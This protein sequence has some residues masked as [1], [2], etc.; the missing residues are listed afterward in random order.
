M[1]V[2]EDTLYIEWLE[3][4]EAGVPLG[5]LKSARNLN[6]KSWFF[7]N[8]PDDKRRVLCSY[9]HLKER[10]QTMICNKFGNPYDYVAKQPIRD[11]VQWDSTAEEYFLNYRYDGDKVLSRSHVDKYTAAAN[12]LNM[13]NKAC[14]D[15]KQ[16]KKLLG[17]TIDQFY[18]HVT[19]LIKIEKVSLPASY[20]NLKIKQKDYAENGYEVLVSPHFG[21]KRSAKVG[22]NKSENVLLKLLSHP[23]QYDDVFI[24]NQ[25]NEWAKSEGY[26]PITSAAVR[27][28]RVKNEELLTFEREG[29]SAFK[30]KFSMKIRGSRPTAPL[31]L[32]E[33]DDNHIDL[34]FT[35]GTNNHLR[36]KAI[37]VMDSFN[38]YVLGYAYSL[39]I[40]KDLVRAA[41]VNAMHH[42]KEI[43]G[44]WYLPHETK[45][46][47][48]AIKDLKPF[49]ESMG[50]YVDARLGNKHRG[51]IEQ[52][53]GSNHWK[54]CLKLGANNYSGNN[55]TASKRGVNTE[56]LSKNQRVRPFIGDE[57]VDQMEQFFHNLRHYPLSNGMSKQQEWLQAWNELGDE[58]KK[59]IGNELYLSKFGI[60]HNYRGEGVSITSK[61]VDV[62][63]NGEIYCYQ[64][65]VYKPELI[66][67]RVSVIYDPYD[68]SKVLLTDHETVREIAY[69]AQF[70]PRALK[71]HSEGTMSYLKAAQNAQN[72][73]ANKV[74]QK[75]MRIDEELN[76]YSIDAES[77][78]QANILEKSQRQL[79]EVQVNQIEEP[80]TKEINPF[81][82]M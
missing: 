80:K 68:M 8:D 41:Y 56:F 13:L 32:V 70:M 21:N 15:K 29:I 30:D 43:T 22:D 73:H 67:K 72:E 31:Y 39:N 18:V 27:T 81:E 53:F 36:Y 38:N 57:S 42:I 78:L 3:L 66:G 69:T 14:S 12:W 51:Y 75:S 50:N 25:Y 9:E 6:R 40:T 52:F 28:H 1:K 26:K 54:N 11:M 71:D 20:R 65:E 47:K 55:I 4:L 35:D 60:E 33:N 77:I 74:A 2:V 34:F 23:N 62:Q 44:G 76:N 63:I 49:Y 46:D 82:G 37:V 19:D 5:T 17:L 7:I 59:L 48:W 10:Y 58:N 45:S 16:I 79:A 61:G 24:S 64:P